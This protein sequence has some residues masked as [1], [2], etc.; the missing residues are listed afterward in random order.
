PGRDSLQTVL[1]TARMYQPAVVFFEDLDEISDPSHD[2]DNVTQLLD[3]F[4]GITAK[5][6]EIL[7]I[8]T[9]N[10]PERIHKGM[11]RPG[12]LDAVI[13][14]G[15][16]DANGVGRMIRALVPNEQLGHVNV[17]RVYEHM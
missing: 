7:A 13:H 3:T 15:E 11:L 4:D 16:L 1:Q 8:L 10:H 9:T 6:T 5:G 14:I 2:G 17:D 12:R